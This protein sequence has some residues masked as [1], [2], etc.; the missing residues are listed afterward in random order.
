MHKEEVET[1]RTHIGHA[2]HRMRDVEV[3]RAETSTA[4]D[5]LRAQVGARPRV[6]WLRPLRDRRRVWQRPHCRMD[7][8]PSPSPTSHP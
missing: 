7:A 6:L 8:A 3:H 2:D 4:L 5:E 1:L